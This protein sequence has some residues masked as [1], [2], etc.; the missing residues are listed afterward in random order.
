MRNDQQLYRERARKFNRLRREGA[1]QQPPRSRNDRYTDSYDEDD[2]DR[3]WWD[4]AGDEMLSWMGDDYAAR[5][6]RHD[7]PNYR[8]VGPKNYKRLDERIHDEVNDRLTDEWNIDASDIEVNVFDGEVI[9]TGYVADRFQKRTAEDV[10]ESV[11][12]VRNVE[13]RLRVEPNTPN[14][15]RELIF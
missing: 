14:V 1:L 11:L 6:R 3:T 10:A 4:R 9:L 8:G 5:R 2:T 12:G 7:T 13:N 15:N